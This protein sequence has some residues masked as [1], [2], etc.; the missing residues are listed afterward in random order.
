[1]KRSATVPMVFAA[2]AMLA[3]PASAE[4]WPPD[5]YTRF[6]I[7]YTGCC[8]VSMA[9]NGHFELDC[10]GHPHYQG[11][12][13]GKWRLI[14]DENCDYPY[15]SSDAYEVCSSGDSCTDSSGTWT[16]I[17]EAQFYSYY[18]P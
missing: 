14:S 2:L 18:C 13:A 12:R 8:G 15:D 16:S 11:T 6:V 7:Y 1:M 9:Y 5:G 10:S 3:P 17:T 4:D